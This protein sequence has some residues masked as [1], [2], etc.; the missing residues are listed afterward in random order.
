ML[1]LTLLVQIGEIL[2]MSLY[3]ANIALSGG[4]CTPD[5]L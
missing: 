5:V 2:I 1:I 4:F 3:K